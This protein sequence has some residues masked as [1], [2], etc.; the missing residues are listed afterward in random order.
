MLPTCR[1]DDH[2]QVARGGTH[3]VDETREVH[4][5]REALLAARAEE[6]VVV[7]RHDRLRLQGAHDALDVAAREAAARDAAQ[8]DIYAAIAE[9]VLEQI[10]RALVIEARAGDLDVDAVDLTALVGLRR[11]LVEVLAGQLAGV[12]DA[13]AELEL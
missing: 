5:E 13:A 12:R 3:L 9:L 11:E 4:V 1:Q 7:G 2:G 10:R 8:E 6:I